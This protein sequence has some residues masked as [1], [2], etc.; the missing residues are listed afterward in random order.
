MHPADRHY[1]NQTVRLADLSV[2]T[3]VIENVT[4]ENCIIEGPAVVVMQGSQV[5]NTNLE[6]DA[7]A[8]FWIIPTG[9]ERVIGAI[10]LVNC[11]IVGCQLRRIGIGV[12]EADYETYRSGFGG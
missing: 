4:F 1:R 12:P 6:G 9:R 11:A 3:D 8:C 2:V 5:M 10:A 7:E